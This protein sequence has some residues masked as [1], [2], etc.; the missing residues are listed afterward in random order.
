EFPAV[1]ANMDKNLSWTSSLGDAYINQQQDVMDAIQV[2]RQRAKQAGN[3]ESTSQLTVKQ[4]AQ[5]IVIEPAEPEVV[6]VPQYDPWIVYGGA[7]RPSPGRC[8]GSRV[9]LFG[10]RCRGGL[11]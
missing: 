11:W 9:F 8:W 1:L 3:L 5:S 10:P 4:Q 7:N 6:Y 2:M